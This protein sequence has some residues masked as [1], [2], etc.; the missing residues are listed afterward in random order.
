MTQACHATS[1]A[2]WRYRDVKSVQE[3]TQDID[4]MHKVVLETKNETSLLKI[5]EGFKAQ[6][7]PHH[8]WIEQPENIPTCVATAPVQRSQ[9]RDIVKKCQLW[10]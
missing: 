6:A 2:L 7:I 5:T 10:R 8:L 3:Y 1:A 9:I 4:N